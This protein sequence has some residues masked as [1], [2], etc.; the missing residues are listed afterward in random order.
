[1]DLP[2]ENGGAAD[3]PPLK[4]EGCLPPGEGERCLA[5]AGGAELL[6]PRMDRVGPA[7]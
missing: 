5:P 3:L 6:P 2:P 1:M 7:S 4:E